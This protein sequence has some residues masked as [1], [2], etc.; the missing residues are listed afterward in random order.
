MNIVYHLQQAF[1]TYL[2]STFLLSDQELE[3]CNLALNADIQKQQFGDFNSSAPLVLAR[4]KKTK[5]QQIAQQIMQEFSHPIIKKIELAG[6]GFLNFFLTAEAFTQLAQELYVQQELF[7]KPHQLKKRYINIEFVSANPTG[8]LHFGHGRGAIIGDVLAN[9][10]TFLG[11]SVVKE[12]YINDAGTQIQKLAL[13]F[14]I[15]C[16]QILGLE[17]EIPEGGYHGEYLKTLA[18]T[19]V[20]QY[21]SAVLE[22]SEAFF[23]EYAKKHLLAN[24][25]QTLT[26][27]RIHFD[28]WFSEKKLH[29]DGSIHKAID[30]LEHKGLT[31]YKD[32]AL[33]FASTQFGDDKDRVLKKATGEWTYVAADVAYL[34]NKADRTFDQLFMVLGHDHHSYA[35][36]LQALRQA[37]DIKAALDVILYQLVKIKEDG[38]EVRMS[39]RAGKIISLDDIIETVG[40][41]VARFF[42]LHRKADAQLDFDIELA[43]KKTE[44]N[45]VY[46]IQYAYV[47]IK[48]I[49]TKAQDLYGTV[50]LLNTDPLLLHTDEHF[51]LKKIVS[52]QSILQTIQQNHQTHL[53]SYYLVELANAFHSYY[54]KNRIVDASDPAQSRS[55]L[56]IISLVQKTLQIGLQLLGIS[57][58]DAM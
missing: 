10:L 44:E 20:D 19:C 2:Q 48:S 39:K 58:P 43:L 24:I 15:R 31:Y 30:L 16:Q 36:R 53:L 26:K 14:L 29:A 38:Q 27:Y 18:Q 35:V 42:F 5:P 34:K 28:I 37:L 54:A 6:A 33:W 8:P 46:Y 13:S 41:D 23:A 17:A 3:P 11:H 21:G 55:R 22:E 12:F 1:T 4:L 51:L 47:R 25:Q 9:V 52:L 57:T 40:T 32:E 49:L 7:F 45:P 56:V 50:P